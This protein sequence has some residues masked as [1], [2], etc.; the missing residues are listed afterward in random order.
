MDEAGESD[1]EGMV[2]TP[3]DEVTGDTEEGTAETSAAEDDRS[4]AGADDGD[5]L[6]TAESLEV[7]VA[8]GEM[9]SEKAPDAAIEDDAT[10]RAG[11][12]CGSRASPMTVAMASRTTANQPRPYA[13]QP[14]I[15]VQINVQVLPLSPFPTSAVTS[16]DERRSM[17]LSNGETNLCDSEDEED[18]KHYAWSCLTRS[19]TTHVLG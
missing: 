13:V 14:T 17:I 19:S 6:D 15:A 12:S 10:T 18:E 1:D 8:A 11:S 5:K 7:W 3:F 16:G 9:I 2:L 4:T